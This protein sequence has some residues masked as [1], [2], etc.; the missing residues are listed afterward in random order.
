M[1]EWSTGNHADRRVREAFLRKLGPVRD[2]FIYLHPPRIVSSAPGQNVIAEGVEAYKKAAA[3]VD[4]RL[5]KKVTLRLK[6]APLYE[7]CEVLEKETGVRLRASRGVED[8][9]VTVLVRDKPARDVMRGVARLF[10]YVWSR[11]GDEGGYRY[12]L[13]QDLRSQLLEQELRDRD[14][15]AALLALDAQL[16]G[17]APYLTLSPRELTSRAA[18]ARGAEKKML[19]TLAGSA[20][21]P[22]HVYHRLTPRQ[23]AALVAGQ[24]LIFTMHSGDPDLRLPAEWR[25]PIL[26]ASRLGFTEVDG[27]PAVTLPLGPSDDPSRGTPLSRVEGAVPEVWLEIKRTELEEVRLQSYQIGTVRVPGRPEASN[28]FG[29]FGFVTAR[30]PAVSTPDNAAVNVKLR[31]DPAFKR[32]I[33]VRPESSCPFFAPGTMLKKLPRDFYVNDQG[34]PISK[35]EPHAFGADAW[36]AFHKEAGLDVIADSYTR[37][38]PLQ[39]LTVDGASLFDALVRVGD[40]LGVRWRKDGDLILCR[41]TSYFWDKLKEVPARSLARWSDRRRARGGLPVEDLLEMTALSDHQL[42]SAKVGKVVEHCWDLEEWGLIGSGEIRVGLLPSELLPWARFAAMLESP[43]LDSALKPQGVALDALPPGKLRAMAGVLDFDAESLKGFRLRI[44][45][46]PAG[47]FIWSPH[48]PAEMFLEANGWMLASGPTPTAA[49]AAARRIRPE[50]AEN[51]IT[52]QRGSLA[53]VLI[54]PQGPALKRG[55]PSV[56]TQD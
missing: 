13:I 47:H 10:G 34:A 30:S 27:R 38:S 17:Y 52:Q 49:L 1:A 54:P 43:Q 55:G 11:T 35:E 18:R 9:N 48:V 24:R 39:K 33:S 36:E 29:D 28:G 50:A 2:D 26:E 21:G 45:Y 14:F 6:R 46:A 53:I 15:H 32:R 19:E 16:A 8:E 4:A 3:T 25:E 42:S 40:N 41:S 12:E 5:F 31:A 56:Y 20:W 51:Q 44:D 22:V 7:L 23:R 37:H